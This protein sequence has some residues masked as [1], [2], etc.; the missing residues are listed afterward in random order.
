MIVSVPR[1]CFPEENR[2]S[3][4]P[5]SV[6]QL[7]KAGLE[8]LVESSAGEAAGFPDQQYVDSGAK[9]VD[10]RSDLFAA[11]V[12]LQV[13]AAGANSDA[14]LAD[15]EHSTGRRIVLAAEP[16]P[17]S[18]LET[19]DEVIE[20]F[21]TRL[22]PAGPHAKR[23]LGVCYDAC[24]QAVQFEDMAASV[25]ALRAAGVPI[26]KVQLSSAIRVLDPRQHLDRLRPFAEDRWFHQVVAR[27]GDGR[28]ERVVD[29]PLA[30]QDV[31]VQQA[32]EWRIHYHVP[33]FSGELDE[34]GLALC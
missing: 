1:E 6:A 3:L 24:H 22:L 7:V 18:F 12:I 21:T 33:I 2:V 26:A 16:E 14:G 8:V 13:R 23:H 19:T 11:D 4:I 10:Q 27:H 5:A 17:F 20:F 29:L 15:L 9:I 28:I 34:Q 30:L 25:G 31:D 32:D